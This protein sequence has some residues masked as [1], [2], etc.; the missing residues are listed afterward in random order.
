MGVSRFE[1]GGVTVRGGM[2]MALARNWWALAVRG[3]AGI[4]FGLVAFA[5]PVSAMLT[6][7]LVFAVY[8][9]VDGVFAIAAAIRAAEHHE[10]WSLLLAEGVLNLAM[11]VLVF[12]FPTGAVLGFVLLTAAWAL[13]T[14]GMM[15]AASFRLHASHGRVWLALGGIV[16]LL[17][18]AV[19]IASPL[20]GALVLTWWLGGYALLFGVV[21]LV[22][23]V[24]LRPHRAPV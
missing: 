6:L 16:S 13:M 12:L 1:D 14:G 19:L 23:A 7:A 9:L 24:R 2:S 15:L 8:L 22:L 10:R 3:V 11:G 17:W 5:A 21:M 20:L 4:V 18:G